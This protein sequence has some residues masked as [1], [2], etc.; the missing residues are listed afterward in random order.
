MPEKFIDGTPVP[1]GYQAA[2]TQALND[3]CDAEEM[4]DID[5]LERYAKDKRQVEEDALQNPNLL[6]LPRSE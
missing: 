4:F 6:P 2:V 3:C 5:E 1:P